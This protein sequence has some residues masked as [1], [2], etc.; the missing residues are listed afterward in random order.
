ME[1]EID[2]LHR[3]FIWSDSMKVLF[4]NTISLDEN[5]LTEFQKK[6]KDIEEFMYMSLWYGLLY[7][8][9]EGW[10]KLELSDPRIDTL[11][12]DKKKVELLHLYRH[13]VFHF[14]EKYNDEKF[15][16]LFKSGNDIVYWIRDLRDAFSDWFLDEI[17]SRKSKKQLSRL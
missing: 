16:N 8:L 3:Y 4:E 17:A 13:G 11:L 1:K 10:R 5:T 6:Q 15:E 14:H 2:T 12:L 7:V 9:I